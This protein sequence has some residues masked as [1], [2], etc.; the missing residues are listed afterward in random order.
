MVPLQLFLLFA[1]CGI[2]ARLT[3]PWR[4]KAATLALFAMIN[5]VGACEDIRWPPDVVQLREE[6]VLDVSC[7]ALATAIVDF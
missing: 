7:V 2:A 3:W 4:N 6:A 1:S 5:V